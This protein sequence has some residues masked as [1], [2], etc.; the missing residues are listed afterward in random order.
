LRREIRKNPVSAKARCGEQ[1][2]K[3]SN[4]VSS[5]SRFGRLASKDWAPPWNFRRQSVCFFVHKD[6]TSE[7]LINL[8][9]FFVGLVTLSKVI[10]MPIAFS[11]LLI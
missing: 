3:K 7:R 8:L 1:N 11:F 10:G 9:I 6:Q 2:P 5:R 4:P